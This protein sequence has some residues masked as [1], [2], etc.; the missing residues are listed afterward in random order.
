MNEELRTT[1]VIEFIGSKV[2]LGLGWSAIS[3]EMKEQLNI[4]ASSQTIKK[5]YTAFVDKGRIEN[6][7][8]NEEINQSVINVTEQLNKVN[9]IT[10]ELLDKYYQIEKEGINSKNL[11]NVVALINEIVK[12]IMVQEKILERITAS[13][14]TTTV[15][16]VYMTK[17]MVNNLSEWEKQGFIKVIKMPMLTKIKDDKNSEDNVSEPEGDE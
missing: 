8:I 11:F 9:K 1:K 2:A 5:I 4:T 7:K 6:E 14:K 3:R 15:S 13:N 10:N 16:N 17:I 12:Q